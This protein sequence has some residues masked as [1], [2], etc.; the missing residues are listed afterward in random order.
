MDA[1]DSS[2]VYELDQDPLVMKY[3]NGGSPSTPETHKKVQERVAKFR[4]PERGWG[5]WGAFEKSSQAFC[6][7]ILVRPIGFFTASP[8]WDNMEIGWRFRQ[9]R[10]GQSYA[11]EAARAVAGAMARREDVRLLSAFV[12]PENVASVR[13]IEKLGL[14]LY[15]PV[16]KM[17]PGYTDRVVYYQGDAKQA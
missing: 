6:G 11:T 4:N 16:P 10:W 12:D 13:V 8:A 14:R 7:W 17:E 3:I 5:L 1:K 15:T 9:T 2:S